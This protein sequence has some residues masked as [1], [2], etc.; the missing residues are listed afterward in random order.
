MHVNRMLMRHW[1]L[2]C[3]IELGTE[4]DSQG[5]RLTCMVGIT[6]IDMCARGVEGNIHHLISLLQG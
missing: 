4:I 2:D 6:T 3:N 5:N 1:D